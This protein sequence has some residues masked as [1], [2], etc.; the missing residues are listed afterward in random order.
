MKQPQ[1]VG[2]NGEKRPS[3]P[4]ACAQHVFKIMVGE[5]PNDTPR[6]RGSLAQP[7][8]AAEEGVAKICRPSEP[9]D[10]SSQ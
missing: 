8:D 5:L 1:T 3:D 10:L 4:A 9:W 6:K 2:P 7:H